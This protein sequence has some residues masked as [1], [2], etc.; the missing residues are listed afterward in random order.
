[1]QK[2]QQEIKLRTLKEREFEELSQ[3]ME[4]LRQ[5]HKVLANKVKEYNKFEAYLLKVVDILPQGKVC[6]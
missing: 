6:L 2:Y 3:E 4:V 1:M 5:V